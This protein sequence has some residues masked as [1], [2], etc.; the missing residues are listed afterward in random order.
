[1]PLAARVGERW[2]PR[3]GSDRHGMGGFGQRPRGGRMTQTYSL[4]QDTIA[5]LAGLAQQLRVD[6]V[7]ASSAAGSGHP[8]SSLSAADLMAVLLASYLRY[9]FANPD[10]PGN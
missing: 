3:R 8:T 9:D 4:G 2:E 6:S 5:R 10:A 7:R 1:M